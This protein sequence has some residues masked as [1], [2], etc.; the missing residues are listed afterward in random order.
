MLEDLLVERLKP[1][2]KNSVIWKSMEL[3]PVKKWKLQ[4]S[5]SFVI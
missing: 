5:M 2:M 4:I 1:N 3:T